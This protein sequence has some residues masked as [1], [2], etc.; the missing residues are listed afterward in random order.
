MPDQAHIIESEGA[1]LV[2]GAQI[3]SRSHEDGGQALQDGGVG[4][5]PRP[6]HRIQVVGLGPSIDDGQR[7]GLDIARHGE[8]CGTPVQTK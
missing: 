6:S 1:G 8:V 7:D 3:Q 4:C 5:Q 2:P